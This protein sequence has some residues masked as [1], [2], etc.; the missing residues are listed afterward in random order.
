MNLDQSQASYSNYSVKTLHTDLSLNRC[1]EDNIYTTT[2]PL[3]SLAERVTNLT[4]IEEH[5]DGN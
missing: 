3:Q 1:K 5:K 4:G 2:L